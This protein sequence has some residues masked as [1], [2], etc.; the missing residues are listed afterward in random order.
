MSLDFHPWENAAHLAIRTDDVRRSHNA[1][2][3]APVHVFLLPNAIRFQRLV[4][5]IRKQREIQFVLVSE[6]RQSRYRVATDPH[7]ARIQFVQFFFG[8][9]ELVRLA[10]S[11]RRIGLGEKIENQ[12]PVAQILQAH[13]DTAVGRQ[14]KAGCFVTRIQHQVT[15][16]GS[17]E[18]QTQGHYPLSADDW[19][20]FHP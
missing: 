9:T 17:S 4:L 2:A 18:R 5:L 15:P 13:L 1:H 14:S 7:D 19:F 8:V 6:L 12:I 10:G 16:S 11:T 3:F 20:N